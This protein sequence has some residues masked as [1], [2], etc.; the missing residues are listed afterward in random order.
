[1]TIA[2]KAVEEAMRRVIATLPAELMRSVT[3][4]HGSEM[5]NHRSI[6]VAAG[7]SVSAGDVVAVV[8]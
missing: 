4:D 1:M 5:S 6:T 8:Q 7:D 3:W 2:A